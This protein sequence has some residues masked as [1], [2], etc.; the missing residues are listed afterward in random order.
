MRLQ[1][2]AGRDVVLSALRR[3]MRRDNAEPLRLTELARQL[4]GA[5]QMTRALEVILS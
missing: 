5:S 2:I 4:G 1:R 3:Y